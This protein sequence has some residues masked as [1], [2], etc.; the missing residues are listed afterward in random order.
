MALP[1]HRRPYTE[2]TTVE[3]N[4]SHYRWDQFPRGSQGL[5]V[6]R[7]P[8]EPPRKWRLQT[9]RGWSPRG[10]TA[11]SSG[12]PLTVLVLTSYPVCYRPSH[13]STAA[14]T[15][16]FDTSPANWLPSRPSATNVSQPT[17]TDFHTSSACVVSSTGSAAASVNAASN[18]SPKTD[19]R[20]M[21][22]C[23]PW[24]DAPV[25]QLPGPPNAPDTDPGPRY[26][27]PLG[28]PSREPAPAG[29]R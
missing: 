11:M 12:S 16:C 18:G 22:A 4:L 29:W 6:F 24:D 15:T 9:L 14:G 10:I 17:D 1:P 20:R 2:D 13:C 19:T 23:T 7:S 28:T 26:G 5:A 25:P 21:P 3:A 8:V 27:S